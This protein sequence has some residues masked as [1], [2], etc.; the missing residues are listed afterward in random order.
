MNKFYILNF[1]QTHI[2]FSLY[3]DILILK[4]T[5]KI[6]MPPKSKEYEEQHVKLYHG[7]HSVKGCFFKLVA[8]HA[9]FPL[10]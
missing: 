4:H 3:L 8:T 7:L 10:V 6:N 5:P 9:T 2:E 1:N